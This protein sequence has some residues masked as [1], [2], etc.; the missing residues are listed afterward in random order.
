MSGLGAAQNDL[1]RRSYLGSS[2]NLSGLGQYW[3]I[4]HSFGPQWDCIS[5]ACLIH[6]HP[7]SS[8]F[9]VWPHQYYFFEVGHLSIFF[10]A[11]STQA[12]DVRH[13]WVE[14]GDLNFS[15]DGCIAAVTV[16]CSKVLI[17]LL[18]CPRFFFGCSWFKVKSISSQVSAPALEVSIG[19]RLRAWFFQGFLPQYLFWLE[20]CPLL[21][22][23]MIFN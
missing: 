1:I 15:H 10:W 18:H 2:G 13:I 5:C 7:S 11:L 20:A 23:F 3:P 4:V 9:G 21:P 19:F 12:S 8:D 6:R 16:C 17:Q 22:S 14:E